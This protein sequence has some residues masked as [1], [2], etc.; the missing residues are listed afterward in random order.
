MPIFMEMGTG[1][2]KVLIDKWLC[3]MIK[4]KLMELLIIAPKGVIGT[5]Y[6]QELPAHLVDHI[7]NV[8]VLWQANIN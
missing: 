4:V 5:W 3:S 1:K 7:E 8:T 6:N 2:T